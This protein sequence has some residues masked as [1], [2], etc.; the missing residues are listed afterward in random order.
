M[1]N[2]AAI[3]NLLNFSTAKGKEVGAMPYL[4][5]SLIKREADKHKYIDFE[6]SS[7]EGIARFYKSFGAENMPYYQL[8]NN[9]LPWMLKW[10][11]K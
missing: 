1:F 4:I 5:D 11:K 8:K 10:T 9:K 2:G 3:V 7:V 6:G